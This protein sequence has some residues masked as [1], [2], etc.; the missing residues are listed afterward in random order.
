MKLQRLTDT[1]LT[2]VEEIS[3]P[4]DLL[5][6]DEFSWNAV[7]RKSEYSLTGALLVQVARKL[8]GRPI[9][10]SPPD[11]EMAW[12]DR[13]TAEKLIA[14]G[15][16]T[17]LRMRLVLEY[18]EDTRQFIVSFADGDGPVSA[19]PVRGFPGHSDSDEFQVT[20]SLK[21]IE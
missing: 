6:T 21:E 8:M 2:V 1:G 12:V 19:K 9:S 15:D 7:V 14:W 11:Q 3:L 10:L 16:L 17:I 4:N 5:W 20:L 18:P 13:S